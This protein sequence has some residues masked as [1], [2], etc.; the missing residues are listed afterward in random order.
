MSKEASNTEAADIE[1]S[2]DEDR[3]R[4]DTAGRFTPITGPAA[5]L[6]LIK[7]RVSNR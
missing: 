5:M 2:A 1:L 6:D 3:L 7:A 4:T